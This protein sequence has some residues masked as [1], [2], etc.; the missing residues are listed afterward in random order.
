MNPG[1][2]MT[3]IRVDSQKGVNLNTGQ[4][5]PHPL[6]KK[7]WNPIIKWLRLAWTTKGLILTPDHIWTPLKSKFRKFGFVMF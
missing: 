5:A 2:Q 3:K 6:R 1:P 7:H 4:Y